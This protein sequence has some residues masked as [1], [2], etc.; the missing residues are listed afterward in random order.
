V[1]SYQQ[2]REKFLCFI[3]RHEYKSKV[4]HQIKRGI[5]STKRTPQKSLSLVRRKP[6]ALPGKA[7]GPC[8]YW[9]ASVSKKALPSVQNDNSP[10]LLTAAELAA[11]IG[12]P[13][14]TI[15]WL[16]Q[17]RKIPRVKLGHRTVR[18]R[19]DAVQRALD[20]LVIDEIR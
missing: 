2:I 4:T 8:S 18:Y 17:V 16:T 11:K 19:L 1:R 15:L 7:K 3:N 9:F 5:V 20:R 12:L 14:R 13:E 10:Y 6:K